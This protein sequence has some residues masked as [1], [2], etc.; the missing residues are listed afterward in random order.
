MPED[1]H[2]ANTFLSG[3]SR[4]GSLRVEF[5]SGLHH[6]EYGF[7][8]PQVLRF[9]TGQFPFVDFFNYDGHGDPATQVEL[10]RTYLKAM[11]P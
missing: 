5:L 11:E 4:P 6:F 10:A 7:G 2:G 3:A 1:F 9:M 8:D